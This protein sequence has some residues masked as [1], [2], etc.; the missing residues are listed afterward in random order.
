MS[1]SLFVLLLAALM[2]ACGQKGPLYMP[3]KLP[4]PEATAP[5]APAVEEKDE[6][7]KDAVVAPASPASTAKPAPAAH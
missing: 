7:K 2:A 3:A 5:A 6:E 1:R 4:V